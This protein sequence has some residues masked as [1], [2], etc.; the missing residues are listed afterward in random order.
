MH[1]VI[2]PSTP[3]VIR[4]LD[5]PVVVS[6]SV[7]LRVSPGAPIVVK[8]SA[9]TVVSRVSVATVGRIPAE[10]I[11]SPVRSAWD[12]KG[13]TRRREQDKDVYE[14]SYQVGKRRFR[15]RIEVGRR[16][17]IRAYILNP[18][19]EIRRHRHRACF[20]QVGIGTGWQCLHWQRSPRTVDE[21]LLYFEQVLDESI[22]G[23]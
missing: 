19:A 20:Q 21:A 14:G 17:R 16:N 12:E 15:G 4:P 6:P 8:R 10:T 1:T 5:P 9:P 3:V 18:P 2:G 11:V 13:W 23:R 22:H 7:P